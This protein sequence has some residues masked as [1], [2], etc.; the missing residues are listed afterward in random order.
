MARRAEAA[1]LI[2]PYEPA[3]RLWQ[4]WHSVPGERDSEDLEYPIRLSRVTADAF[5]IVELLTPS[6]ALE[7]LFDSLVAVWLD[8]TRYESSVER[9][10]LH[11]AYQQI[12]GLGPM[13]IPLILRDLAN[14]PNH[15]FWALT[16]LSREDPASD[17]DS[18]Q[19]ARDA[20]LVWGRQHGYID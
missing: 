17:L 2:T 6:S 11:T 19:D 4:E 1:D 8:E 16:A 13:A 9:I 3:K 7:S 12:I 18:L 14:R 10:V 20:W 15:W 5:R